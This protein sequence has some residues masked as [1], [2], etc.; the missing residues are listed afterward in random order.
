VALLRTVLVLAILVI[1]AYLGISYFGVVGEG[2]GIAEG[3]NALAELL[4]LPA[5][6]LLGALPLSESQRSAVDAGGLY[7]IGIAACAIYFVLFLLLGVGR[8]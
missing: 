8:R 5:A 4:I 7:S 1:L 6:A 2:N 3:V